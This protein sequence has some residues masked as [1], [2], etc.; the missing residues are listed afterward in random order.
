MMMYS[1][2]IPPSIRLDFGRTSHIDH[3]KGEKERSSCGVL[4]AG[5]THVS[6]VSC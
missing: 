6:R 5:C 3:L 1:G 2:N 4:S